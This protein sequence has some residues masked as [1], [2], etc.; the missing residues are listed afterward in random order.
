M[1]TH[2]DTMK[3][4]G[5]DICADEQDEAAEGF[6]I[7]IKE[8]TEDVMWMRTWDQMQQDKID[9]SVSP[10]HAKPKMLKEKS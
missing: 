9:C 2:V 7:W 10:D 5:L 4:G 1:L 6:H 3:A 8:R